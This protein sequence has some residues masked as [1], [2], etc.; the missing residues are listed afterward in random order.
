MSEHWTSSP[1]RPSCWIGLDF[2]K[3]RIKL[4]IIAYFAMQLIELIIM[5]T[6]IIYSFFKK[7]EYKKKENS[8]KI[9]QLFKT[10]SR[11]LLVWPC[12]ILRQVLNF[13][14]VSHCAKRGFMMN[15][16][17]QILDW[18]FHFKISMDVSAL[19]DMDQDA[20]HLTGL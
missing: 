11:M 19:L 1:K 18:L 14:H 15:T 10:F 20:Q 16:N 2:G 9:K 4:H 3:E 12:K 8:Y 5:A 13:K 7:K 6:K 17:A